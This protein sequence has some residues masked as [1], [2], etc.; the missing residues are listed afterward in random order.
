M[1]MCLRPAV[2][3]FLLCHKPTQVYVIRT[4]QHRA[5]MPAAKARKKVAAISMQELQDSFSTMSFW[6]NPELVTRML[7]E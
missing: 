1:L 5:S 6:S 3:G 4:L 7:Q 2:W